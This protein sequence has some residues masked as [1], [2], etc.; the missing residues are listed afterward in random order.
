MSESS[1]IFIYTEGDPSV[2]IYGWSVVI[3]LGIEVEYDDVEYRNELCDRFEAI[4]T[5][6]WDFKAHANFTDTCAE[7]GG[8]VADGKCTNK[9]YR[10]EY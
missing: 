3:D 10:E 1:S 9:C 2:G 8:L 5:E 6:L 7:C 4:Y